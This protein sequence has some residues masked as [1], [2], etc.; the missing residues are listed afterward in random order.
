MRLNINAGLI[1]AGLAAL[2][3]ACAGLAAGPA[4]AETQAQLLNQGPPR[5]SQPKPDP[6]HIP[7]VFGKDIPWKCGNGECSA[8]L[9]GDSAKPGIY[10]VLIKWEP[11][12]NSQPHFH[13]TDRYVY[14][15]SGSWWVSSSTHYDPDKMYPIPAGSFVTDIA[16]TVHWDGAKAETGP[17]IIMLV[18]EGPMTSTRYV[19]KDAGKPAKGQ[20]FVP[21]PK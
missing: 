18:G 10:G 8:K 20:D 14:V 12:H 19:P 15:V 5:T 9:F 21:P 17:C 4:W 3:I 11:G 6:R 1:N 2:A 16:N 7:I 13:S